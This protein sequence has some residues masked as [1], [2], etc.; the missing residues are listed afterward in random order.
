MP[1][2]T[3]NPLDPRDATAATPQ[4]GTRANADEMAADARGDA[5]AGEDVLGDGVEAFTD[6]AAV[7]LLNRIAELE[8]E[9]TDAK[10]RALRLMADFNNYQRRALQNEVAAE[11]QGAAK[12]VL[13][14]V[15]VIDH[16][17][18]ALAHDGANAS[19]QQ[20]LQGVKV[21]REELLKALHAHGV[22][23]ITPARGEPFVP[24]R[25]EALMQQAVEGLAPG[26]IAQ[27]FQCG[28]AIETPGGGGGG[29]GIQERVVRPAK[30]VVVAG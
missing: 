30:V 3:T 21:I 7:G 24:G 18:H 15:P 17:D 28:F 1:D 10:S 20:V 16:F 2:D 27:V 11:H 14:V 26:T 9:L 13:S 5:G 12:V 25:H 29:G 22:R 4:P 8:A 19:A 6:E 23:T